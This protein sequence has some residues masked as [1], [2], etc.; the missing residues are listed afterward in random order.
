MRESFSRK[1]SARA[2][3]IGSA[4]ASIETMP[5]SLILFRWSRKR[6]EGSLV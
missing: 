1:S 2:A 5:P 4:V 6:R 3:R